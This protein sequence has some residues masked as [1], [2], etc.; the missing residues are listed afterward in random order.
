MK[1]VVVIG[2]A[3]AMG[4]IIVRDLL[5]TAPDFAVV[6]GE[7][8]L[9]VGHRLVRSLRARAG[10]R[11]RAAQVDAGDE[12][13]VAALA[14]GAFAVINAAGH[15]FNLA[16]MRGCLVAGAHYVD[17]GGLFHV[18]REQYRLHRDFRR[19]GL[20]ALLGIGAA[21]G[22]TNLL[23]RSVCDELQT[24]KSIQLYI[25]SADQNRVLHE[26][27]LNASYSLETI[28]D[29]CTQP[30]AVFRKGRMTFVEPM[31][32]QVEVDFPDPVGRQRPMYT[33]HSEVLQLSRTYRRRGIEEV[34]FRIALGEPLT[35]RLAFLREL[36]MLEKEPV[37][38]NGSQ[39]A[40]R[41]LL[42][43]LL[44]RFP[45]PTL[46]GP[47]REHE[48]LRAEV[49]GSDGGPE[50]IWTVDCHCTGMPEWGIGLDIDTGAPP[51]IA[52]Q[53]LARGEI[54]LRGAVNPEEAI[55]V[56]PF[57]AELEKRGIWIER[58]V[59]PARAAKKKRSTRVA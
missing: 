14:R 38:V 57:F 53:L 11:L 44:S 10:R 5:E 6:I 20:T 40:P 18:T 48:V 34:G 59:R 21:P 58:R 46:E 36:G 7:R 12:K 56:A 8:D 35:E 43:E 2:G 49:V 54:S 13:A 22:I 42:I 16:V 41:A 26:P 52:V 25:A 27:P 31:S 3:G 4:R 33:I 37:E 55:P 24:V 9:Q 29:E 32:G 28:F 30:P 51:S 45:P 17:L 50:K 1:T 47:P 19:Q 39:V 15:R 23:A